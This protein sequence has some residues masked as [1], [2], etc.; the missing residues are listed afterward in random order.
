M[1]NKDMVLLSFIYIWNFQ[2]NLGKGLGSWSLK[3]SVALWHC[4]D[5]T[6]KGMLFLHKIDIEITKKVVSWISDPSGLWDFFIFL[7]FFYWK[8]DSKFWNR[9]FGK[10]YNVITVVWLDIQKN[11]WIKLYCIPSWFISASPASATWDAT[12]FFHDFNSLQSSLLP[13]NHGHAHRGHFPHQVLSEQWTNIGWLDWY[14][15]N[16]VVLIE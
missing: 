3:F 9:S 12:F 5:A 10:T 15:A 7:F 1:K 16:W 13:R 11:L 4:W 6:E 14:C 2:A 8:G